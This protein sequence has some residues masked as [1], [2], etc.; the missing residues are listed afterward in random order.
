MAVAAVPEWTGLADFQDLDIN[1]LDL[2]GTVE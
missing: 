2:Y 1:P